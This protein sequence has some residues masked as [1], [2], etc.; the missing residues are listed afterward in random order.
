ML[1]HSFRHLPG[2]TESIEESWWSDGLLTWSD[3]EG[4]S[5]VHDE[6]RAAVAESVSALERRDS[7]HFGSAL[8]ANAAWRLYA[9]FMEDAAFLDI[10]TTGLGEDS[11]TTMCGVLDRDGFHAYVRGENLDELPEALEKY[12]L[13][14]SYNGIS[15]DVPFLRREFGPVLPNAAHVDLMYVLRRLGFKGGLKKVEQAIGV[16]RPGE[17]SDLDGRAAVTLWN[18]AQTGEPR[19]LET[20]IRY[21]AE[22]VAVLPRLA[23]F[24]VREHIPGTPMSVVPLPDR[25][26]YDAS[27][28]PYDESLV[29]YLGRFRWGW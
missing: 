13:V 22:D 28:L 14:Y 17:L 9:D 20:L 1:V 27:M 5:R 10:E 7:L 25:F 24:A 19:A 12:R 29:E 11:Y 8:P 16:G 3:V 26:E 23:E 2:V 15:F 21:N 6:A 18:M 4:S